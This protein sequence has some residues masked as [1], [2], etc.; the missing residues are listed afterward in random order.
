MT[1]RKHVFGAGAC[2]CGYS[3][4]DYQAG[5]PNHL[6]ATAA[7][8]GFCDACGRLDDDHAFAELL[9]CLYADAGLTREQADG[10]VDRITAEVAE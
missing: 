9:H 1:G 8:E 6:E 5:G 10:I 2:W 7:Q 4:A 3:K